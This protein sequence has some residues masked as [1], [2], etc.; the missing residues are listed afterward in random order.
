[1]S[2]M[3]KEAAINKVKIQDLNDE[4]FKS[5]EMLLCRED[6]I[7]QLKTEIGK[8]RFAL[9]KL[10]ANELWAKG[11]SKEYVIKIIEK[12]LNND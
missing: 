5:S 10:R 1:M 8:M 11:H 4:L 2:K 9:L 12:A 7:H 3:D 6:E